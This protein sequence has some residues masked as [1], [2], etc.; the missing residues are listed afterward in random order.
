MIEL[1]VILIFII[2]DKFYVVENDF[3][4]IEKFRLVYQFVIDFFIYTML[5]TRSN[6]VS[7]IFMIFRYDLNF[8]IFY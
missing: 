3:V 2:N 7:A 6:I 5:N 8:D 1:I 4:I